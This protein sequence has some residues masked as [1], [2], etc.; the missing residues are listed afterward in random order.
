MSTAAPIHE[1]AEGSEEP[2]ITGFIT[3]DAINE[4]LDLKTENVAL[5]V[6]VR[7]LEERLRTEVKPR[8]ETASEAMARMQ[9]EQ[10]EKQYRDYVN[11][12]MGGQ[13]QAHQAAAD[14]AQFLYEEE[15]RHYRTRTGGRS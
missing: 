13:W 14:R 3:L 5:K 12:M 8:P 4:L 7:Y 10:R 1:K 6:Y 2:T 11:T 9:R 15:L